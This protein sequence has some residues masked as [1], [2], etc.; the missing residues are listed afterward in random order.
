MKELDELRELIKNKADLTAMVAPSFPIMFEYPLI[1]A[2]LKAVGFKHVV[3]VAAGADKTNQAVLAA[4]KSD[5]KARFITSPCPSIV[6]M[7]RT[8]FPQLVPFLAFAADSPMV[9]TARLV[10][11]KFPGS[12]PIFLGPCN[13]KT[14]EAREDY[15]ELNIL[16]VPYR[17]LEILFK[18]LGGG[19]VKVS[20]EDQFELACKKTRLYPMSGGLAQSSEVKNILSDD[21]IEV[22]SGWQNDEVALKKFLTDTKVRLLDILFCNGGCVSG[23]GIN[24]SLTLDQRREKVIDF[25][26]QKEGW[27]RS[28]ARVFTP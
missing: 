7:V 18:E 10:I 27:Q 8:K 24:S 21:E 23:P 1:V 12:R 2:Q 3:E 16:S 9:A 20:K 11:E 28:V 17:D 14:L 22:V 15:P 5:P 4:L 13:A 19:Q 26:H 6:R 25:W